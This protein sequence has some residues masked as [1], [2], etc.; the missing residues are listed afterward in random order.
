[1]KLKL[2]C[3]LIFLYSSL[4]AQWPDAKSI[5]IIHP[6][7]ASK[8][9][10]KLFAEMASFFAQGQNSLAEDMLVNDVYAKKFFTYYTG[11]FL[12]LVGKN[13][14]LLDVSKQG[15][16]L[17]SPLKSYTEQGAFKGSIYYLGLTS[18][19][20][21]LR[22][23]FLGVTKGVPVQSLVVYGEDLKALKRAFQ[24]IQMGFVQ[25]TWTME[26]DQNTKL[27]TQGKVLWGMAYE[28]DKL[29]KSYEPS[30]IRSYL[31][32]GG[33]FESKLHDRQEDE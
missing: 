18:N 6:V 13:N 12:V 4:L 20:L 32:Q 30:N 9:E 2:L 21:F 5:K 23:R 11:N 28:S 15:V 19:P 29:K 17:N 16:K 31:W 7:N 33:V 27:K 3:A 1:V 22:A 25:G 14:L 10:M 8:S 26:E 24:K